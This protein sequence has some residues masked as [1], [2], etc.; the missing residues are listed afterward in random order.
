M[1]LKSYTHGIHYHHLWWNGRNREDSSGVY[2]RVRTRGTPTTSEGV[3]TQIVE[4][5]GGWEDVGASLPV[6]Q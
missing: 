3:V 1:W 6:V 4:W 2:H 5:P